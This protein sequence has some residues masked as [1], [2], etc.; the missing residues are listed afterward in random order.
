MRGCPLQRHDRAHCH[1]QIR[2]FLVLQAS[3]SLSLS[4]I[5]WR[6]SVARHLSITKAPLPSGIGTWVT[7][8]L[9]D[10][11][12][13]RRRPAE[14]ARRWTRLGQL[15]PAGRRRDRLAYYSATAG[16]KPGR[17]TFTALLRDLVAR[18][19]A[20]GVITVAATQ[21]PT[22]EVVSPSLRDLFGYRWAF[23]CTTPHQLGRDPRERV[24]QAGLLRDRDRPR[25]PRCRLAAG[26]GRHPAAD[27]GGV[28]HRRRHPR[29]WPPTPSSS[30]GR[31]PLPALGQPGS[32][33]GNQGRGDDEDPPA[34]LVAV[35]A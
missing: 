25:R 2:A 26:R 22:A 9:Q 18:G 1:R 8:W 29:S 11:G 3:N 24:R 4:H 21:R 10:M 6:R 15:S 35:P 5:S 19:R 30:G 32:R 17:D 27:E 14:C 7:G 23:R 20:A 28:P 16:T 31:Y 33:P 12:E 34:G 13:A